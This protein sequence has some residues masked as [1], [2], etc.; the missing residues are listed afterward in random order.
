MLDLDSRLRDGGKILETVIEP[1]T[2]R[3]FGG[4]KRLVAN[5]IKRTRVASPKVM[6]RTNCRTHPPLKKRKRLTFSLLI[7]YKSPRKKALK[8]TVISLQREF[9]IFFPCK[10][11][12]LGKAQDAGA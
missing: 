7:K 12:L 5:S 8:L 2:L 6:T 10:Q 1:S 9:L 3:R 11:V 4:I